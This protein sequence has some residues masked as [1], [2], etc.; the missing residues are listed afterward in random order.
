MF[1]FACGTGR[2]GQVLFLL[3]LGLA[4]SWPTAEKT[5]AAEPNA[6]NAK[7]ATS[8]V[9]FDASYIPADTAFAAVAHPRQVLTR[10][11]SRCCPSR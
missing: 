2:R 6:V 5:M 1:N 7:T 9:T 10:P 11:T 4:L 8:A 3:A